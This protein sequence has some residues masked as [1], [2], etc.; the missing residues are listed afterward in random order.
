MPKI[1]IYQFD[2]KLHSTILFQHQNKFPLLQV[3][4][5]VRPK[6]PTNFSLCALVKGG[7]GGGAMS[8]GHCG[9]QIA[10]L[11]IPHRVAFAL[12]DRVQA[13]SREENRK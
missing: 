3:L 4:T 10:F 5:L 12:I 9:R 1:P 6:T 13:L 11:D 2:I 7:D 8:E